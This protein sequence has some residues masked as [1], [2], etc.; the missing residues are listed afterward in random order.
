[1]LDLLGKAF[2]AV[3]GAFAL[4]LLVGWLV[5]RFRRCTMTRDEWAANEKAATDRQ[6]R[7][8]AVLA[9]RDALAGQVGGLRA[10]SARLQAALTATWQ[11]RDEL[12]EQ[13]VAF[14]A[15][16]AAFRRQFADVLAHRRHLQRRVTEL[17][18][19]ASRRSTLDADGAA[20]VGPA[21]ARPV[22]RPG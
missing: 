8:E 16:L 6:R 19:S 21:P 5:W 15:E 1:M 10:E 20:G 12:R 11:E 14:D 13:L 9:D 2:A 18:L 17:S 4:G 22:P 7:L 3:G